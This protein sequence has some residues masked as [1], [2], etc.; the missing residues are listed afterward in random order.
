MVMVSERCRERHTDASK[1]TT[2]TDLQCVRPPGGLLLPPSLA[3]AAGLGV[4]N[5]LG[6]DCSAWVQ[7][8][9]LPPRRAALRSPPRKG[10]SD[11]ILRLASVLFVAYSLSY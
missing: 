5:G 10:P 3:S 8:T 6:P 2:Q 11:C 4:Q 7:H 9:H 1:F